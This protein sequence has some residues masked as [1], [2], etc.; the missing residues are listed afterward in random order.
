VK[1]SWCLVAL[2]LAGSARAALPPG[3][4]AREVEAGV[5]RYERPAASQQMPSFWKAFFDLF[6]LKPGSKRP[7]GRSVA[8]LVGVRNYRHLK[9]ALPYT[10][11]DVEKM[12]DYLLGEGGFDLAYVMDERATPTLVQSYMMDKVNTLAGAEDRLLFYF[13]GHGA[14]TDEGGTPYLQFRDA[15]P[16][17][18]SHD[19][20][21]V[22][23]FKVWSNQSRAK[24]M[25]FIFDS[26]F[27][28]D[29][30]A[31]AGASEVAA[32]VAQLSANGS[33]M[34][35][36]AA[37][38]NQRAW[39][40]NASSNSGYSIFT[41]ALVRALREG[42]AD[43]GGRGFVTIEQAV[44]EVQVQ[45]AA[46]TEKLGPGHE[47]KP[48]VDSIPSN[49]KGTFVFL[50]TRAEKPGAP[51][52]DLTF[53]GL[54]AKDASADMKGEAEL[55]FWRSIETLNDP[56]LYEQVCARWP[57]GIFC[58]VARKKI[59]LLK[60]VVTEK[61]GVELVPIP[62]GKF[63]MGS[64]STEVGRY[65]DERQ[66][67]VVVEP[68]LLGRYP[69]TNEQYARFLKEN[70]RVRMPRY[71]EDERY[72]Q[73]RQP[74]VGVSWDEAV[75]F[76]E[77]A[78]GRLPTEAEWEY[79]CR[80]GTT[81]ATYAG[82]LTSQEKDPVLDGI[83]WY[84]GN[85]G[86]RLHPVGEKKPNAWGLYDMLGNVWQWCSDWA[87]PYGA[88][89]VYDPHGPEMGSDRVIRGGSWRDQAR[90]VRAA[91]RSWVAPGYR[92]DDLG[93]RL[94]RGQVAPSQPGRS[95]GAAER[96]R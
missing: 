42:S 82:N 88:G 17:E 71:W 61:G 3:V 19:V 34:V 16:G 50:N 47:M 74:V 13:S 30:V 68:F 49:R 58:P 35:V 93:L 94:L 9:P 8:V 43:H 10:A 14:L 6:K 52:G 39:V 60:P 87:G 28:G 20:L 51:E 2:L 96:P 62:G 72:N 24:H 84:L 29:A 77:W 89:L 59:E 86:G 4:S 1:A 81:T 57:D 44:A 37:S 91:T 36:T 70:P 26:C 15:R 90:T 40:L 48:S 73:P 78:G 5:T 76:A 22:D 23:E 11:R 92:L 38:S 53:M 69:V 83:A 95:P 12:R 65:D 45:L 64:P 31:K 63:M 79:A 75:A 33:R 55:T 7:F 41:D 18:W 67:E 56:A 80:A 85:S 27:A 32:S 46:S 66:H 21:R 25:L 54:E